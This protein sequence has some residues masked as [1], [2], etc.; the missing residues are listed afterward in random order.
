M[1]VDFGGTQVVISFIYVMTVFCYIKFH[2]LRINMAMGSDNVVNVVALDGRFAALTVQEAA[3]ED[4]VEFVMREVFA[5]LPP[6][7]ATLK[8]ERMLRAEGFCFRDLLE[9]L[10]VQD[11]VDLGIVRGHAILLSRL[12]RPVGGLP[13]VQVL[14]PSAQMN[15]RASAPTFPA[16]GKGGL[17]SAR[18]LRAW[19]PAVFD[20]LK[21]RG[22]VVDGLRDVFRAPKEDV[23]PA[24]VHGGAVER[25]L[26]SV[27][28][29]CGKD[30]IP[31]GLML[32]FPASVRE[33]EQGLR[34]WQHLFRRVLLVS[35]QSI[36]IRPRL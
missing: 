21:E 2:S 16:A 26:W 6:A 35:D 20:T 9:A 34:A 18:A 25:E 31:E 17:P 7:V 1:T 13:V 4:A 10:T 5:E 14:Q 28:V 33:G 23:D 30:G 12:L 15:R 22:V 11:M 32:S 8:Y 24:W 36:N 19:M 27:L 29:R 3:D